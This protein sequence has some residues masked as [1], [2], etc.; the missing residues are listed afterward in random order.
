MDSGFMQKPLH[1]SSLIFSLPC[2][3][4]HSRPLI[5]RPWGSGVAKEGKLI[6]LALGTHWGLDKSCARILMS[7]PQLLQSPYYCH[8]HS[9]DQMA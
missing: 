8:L 9:T 3:F 6:H 4:I 1:S 5:Q 2:S 7:L